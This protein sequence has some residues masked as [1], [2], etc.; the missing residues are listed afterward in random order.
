VFVEREER[1]EALVCHS[2]NRP[3]WTGEKRGG[4]VEVLLLRSGSCKRKKKKEDKSLIP[5]CGY[6]LRAG[7][8][9]EKR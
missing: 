5:P 3:R 9:E 7:S 1:V 2:L 6:S 4:V 8:G